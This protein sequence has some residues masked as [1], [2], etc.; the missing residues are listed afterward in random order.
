[1]YKLR[2]SA[3]LGN[4]EHQCNA[5]AVDLNLNKTIHT[6]TCSPQATKGVLKYDYSIFNFFF[7]CFEIHLRAQSAGRENN[8]KSRTLNCCMINTSVS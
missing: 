5:S 1:M 2:M 8:C 6:L 3:V 4:A 7:F